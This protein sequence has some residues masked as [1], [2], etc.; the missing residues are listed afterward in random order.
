MDAII[1][2]ALVEFVE[3]VFARSW[4]GKE[5]EA[6][7]LFVFGYLLKHCRVGTLLYDPAQIGIEVRVPKPDNFGAK[8]EV[9]KDIVIWSRP[10][11]T[12]WDESGNA[13]HQ[14]LTVLEWKVNVA[15]L[16]AYD[17]DWLREF[18]AGQPEFV[19]YAVCLNLK[20][21]AFRLRCARVQ[22]RD[23]QRDWLEL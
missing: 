9:C 8:K 21:R 4:W 20:P 16:S 1:K 11:M 10:G 3:D 22:D 12:C 7:S 2:P 6:V 5:R 13:T 15:E 14:P 18:S 17:L 23:I 19:G